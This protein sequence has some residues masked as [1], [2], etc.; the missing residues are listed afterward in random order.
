LGIHPRA[1]LWSSAKADEDSEYHRSRRK[2]C[3]FSLKADIYQ[4]K[5]RGRSLTLPSAVNSGRM[6][7]TAEGRPREGPTFLN[8]IKKTRLMDSLDLDF[9]FAVDI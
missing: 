1:S 5:T 6:E 2:V 8:R 3:I 7:L 9:D 4:V